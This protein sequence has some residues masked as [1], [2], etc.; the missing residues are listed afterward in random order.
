MPFLAIETFRRSV[1]GF[2]PD[3]IAQFEY[4]PIDFLDIIKL[5]FKLRT[6][7]ARSGFCHAERMPACDL[8]PLPVWVKT[9]SVLV[10][11]PKPRTD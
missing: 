6:T 9:L 4:V 11:E 5:H 3:R 2:Q 7:V 10:F 8:I 1:H